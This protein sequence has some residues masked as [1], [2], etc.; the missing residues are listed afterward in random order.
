MNYIGLSCRRP[1]VR[2]GRVLCRAAFATAMRPPRRSRAVSR[3]DE[4]GRENA[5]LT[6]ARYGCVV[7]VDGT[8]WPQDFFTSGATEEEHRRMLEWPDPKYYPRCLRSG[9]VNP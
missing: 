9:Q 6:D 2:P 3:A 1:P 8:G 7:S 4:L 5:A